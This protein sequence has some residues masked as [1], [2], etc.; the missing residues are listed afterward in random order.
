MVVRSSAINDFR[1]RATVSILAV[2]LLFGLLLIRFANLQIWQH[3]AFA[4]KAENNRVALLPI[5][6]PRGKILDRYGEIL[7]RND[8]GFSVEIEP[9]RAQD[10]KA[11]LEKLTQILD[12]S[13]A[14][15]RRFKRLAAEARRFDNV[16]LKSKLTDEQV[17]KLASQ[18][19]QLPGVQVMRR[20]VRAYPFGEQASHLLGHIGRL[21]KTDVERLEVGELA[22]E[23]FGVTHMGKLGIEK[24]YEEVLRGEVGFQRIEVTAGGRIVR[25]LAMRPAVPGQDLV[26]SIDFGLQQMIE[27][28]YG[29]R[30]G[31]MVVLSPKTGEILAFVSMPNFNPNEFVDGIDPDLWNA[32]N[33]S[34]DK[35]LYNRAL[36][37]VYPPGSTYKPFMAIAALASGERKPGD[38]IQDPGYFMLGSHRFRDSR[39]EGHG[40]VDL[41]KSIVVSSD[42][43]YYKLAIDMGVDTIHQFITPF[44]FGQRTGIDVD[45]EVVGILPSSEWKK[46]RFGKDWLTG[47][48]PSI[49][50]GQGYNAF[51]I[52]QLARATASLA[53]GGKLVRPRLVKAV[54]E[55]FSK[56]RTEIPLEEPQNLGLQPEWL[57]LV[58]EAMVEV[59]LSGT[60]AR[61]FQ[62]ATYQPAGKTGTS[63]VFSVG[64]NEKYVASR[65]AERLRD[66]SLYI[67]FAPAD[68][69]K[70]ALAVVVENGGF[71]AAAAAPLAKKALDYLLV[72]RE[73]EGKSLP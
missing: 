5:Q 50:I 53:N 71:G 63:Q 67:A 36:K 49:G 11:S 73:G 29:A 20:T 23:Y 41:K 33:T 47:E 17:A 30:R 27:E 8:A 48:T 62:G 72:K 6:A 26:L 14:E 64:Q 10:L 15:I 39:P 56:A 66:H 4:V 69:P 22:Q 28:A 54:Q 34:I 68:D 45:G 37:G 51:T 7:A 65:V 19:D 57:Q 38:T 61:V 40:T 1:F 9:G 44:G 60:G 46:K 70:V 12:L 35:P 42:T 13:P 3:D 55:P 24:S 32:L 31:A 2:G 16:L 21:S 58:K 59:N 18:L 52:L 43:Y 25:E